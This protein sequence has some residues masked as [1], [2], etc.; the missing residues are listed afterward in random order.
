MIKFMDNNPAVHYYVVDY[1]TDLF[2]DGIDNW[3]GAIC[4]PSLRTYDNLVDFFNDKK[5]CAADYY[6]DVDISDLVLYEVDW[7]EAHDGYGMESLACVDAAH[8][9]W[10]H[11]L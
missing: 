1:N 10:E 8:D 9:V 6:K 2:P 4:Y 3:C 7:A 5:K 11:V